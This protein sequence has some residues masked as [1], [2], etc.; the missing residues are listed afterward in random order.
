M[1]PELLPC[2]MQDS[3]LFKWSEKHIFDAAKELEAD[4][5]NA[6]VPGGQGSPADVLSK[7]ARE[8][9]SNLHTHR[10]LVSGH[11]CNFKTVTS[12]KD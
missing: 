7:A 5:F 2:N 4:A 12:A 8:L 10:N 1:R 6:Q 3:P 9:L 11:E